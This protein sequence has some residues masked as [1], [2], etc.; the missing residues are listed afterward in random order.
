MRAVAVAKGD[1]ISVGGKSGGDLKPAQAHQ[2]RHLD[3]RQW[4]LRGFPIQGP[5]TN[6]AAKSQEGHTCYP[7]RDPRMFFIPRSLYKRCGN[8]NRRER[9]MNRI[10]ES[11]TPLSHGLNEAGLVGRI[12]Q[13]LA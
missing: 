1:L 7:A 11:I 8:R 3:R 6:R 4:S 10:D 5:E 13:R 12:T 9:S 2:R